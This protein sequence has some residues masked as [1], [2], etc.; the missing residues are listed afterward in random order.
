MDI[1]R[2]A[3]TT[4]GRAHPGTLLAGMLAWLDARTARLTANLEITQD[5]QKREVGFL[6]RAHP[7]VRRALDRVRHLSLGGTAASLDQRISAVVGDVPEPT[8]LFTFLGRIHSRAGR[9]FEQVLAIL[10]HPTPRA[11]VTLRAAIVECWARRWLNPGWRADG[12]VTL[13]GAKRVV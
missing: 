9:E 2:F 5:A 3:P 7:L 11:L 8:L 4:S 10:V 1:G 13:P 6:G 12:P